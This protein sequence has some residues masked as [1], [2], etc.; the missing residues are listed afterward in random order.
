MAAWYDGDE[1]REAETPAV[2]EPDVDRNDVLANSQVAH[3][4]APSVYGQCRRPRID[5]QEVD[6]GQL[7]RALWGEALETSAVDVDGWAAV[8]AEL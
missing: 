4:R 7:H 3:D 8:D 2:G 5:P 6:L 1:V